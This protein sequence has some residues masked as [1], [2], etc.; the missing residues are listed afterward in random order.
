MQ[1][2][3]KIKVN[4]YSHTFISFIFL[5][6][7]IIIYILLCAKNIDKFAYWEEDNY[8]LRFRDEVIQVEGSERIWCDCKEDEKTTCKRYGIF[9][10][11]ECAPN[12]S[13][14]VGNNEIPILISPHVGALAPLFLRLY[15]KVFE[16]LGVWE[17]MDVRERV[18][19]MRSFGILVTLSNIFVIFALTSRIFGHPAAG[20][21][22]ALSSTDMLVVLV[23]IFLHHITFPINYF[24]F[25][26]LLTLSLTITIFIV[27]I[28]IN[29]KLIFILTSILI[30]FLSPHILYS[31]YSL[32]SSEASTV[33]GFSPLKYAYHKLV[34][35]PKD[36]I[37]NFFQGLIFIFGNKL[38]D[39]G[40][41]HWILSGT[42]QNYAFEIIR[43]IFVATGFVS[44]IFLEKNQKLKYFFIL[45]I[46]I[47]VLLLSIFNAGAYH[48]G[49]PSLILYIACAKGIA[50]LK[51]RF[52][53]NTI[54]LYI[55]FVFLLITSSTIGFVI[56]S[57]KIMKANSDKLL[58]PKLQI[59]EFLKRNKIKRVVDILNSHNIPI[60]M[61]T[62]GEIKLV[63][64]VIA[65]V[66]SDKMGFSGIWWKVFSLERNSIFIYGYDSPDILY[67][68]AER[69]GF[70]VKELYRVTVEG[71]FY[72]VLFTI[73]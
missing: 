56:N 73:E 27:R 57:E 31:L 48:Y 51:I 37:R 58:E 45:L 7:S 32:K 21:S 52:K 8:V 6:L 30:I 41:F 69:L 59:V 28:R 16:I 33:W 3:L 5:F 13:L 10:F 2:K 1:G 34:S 54:P 24:P 43:V 26:S 39:A 14:K 18:V 53:S 11:R 19:L 9:I 46:L 50:E 12:L 61:L 38:P 29:I 22:F 66:N 35:S 67:G 4:L 44:F 15:I 25:L 63:S 64:Y 23:P 71:K 65:F 60:G 47:Y 72:F 62:D 68:L 42:G 17:N 20:I 40:R 55:P 36:F 70:K 49:I